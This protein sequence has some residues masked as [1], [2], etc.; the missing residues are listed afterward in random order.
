MY[1]VYVHALMYVFSCIHTGG[2]YV[3]VC[4]Q[5]HACIQQKCVAACI[6]MGVCIAMSYVFI[7]IDINV[8]FYRE[9]AI[10][11]K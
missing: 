5:E 3:F 1:M 11:A 4:V 2:I 6:W 8:N 7:H 9:G 10:S